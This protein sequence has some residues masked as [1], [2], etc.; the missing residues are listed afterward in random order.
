M[1]VRDELVFRCCNPGILDGSSRVKCIDGTECV[2]IDCK[3][4]VT[5]MV[6]LR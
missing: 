4:I 2:R 6:S 1:L 3:L 5:D